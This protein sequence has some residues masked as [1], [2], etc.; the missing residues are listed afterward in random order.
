[1]SDSKYLYYSI[2]FIGLILFSYL[3]INLPINIPLAI[4]LGTSVVVLTFISPDV[5]L[6]VL[7][8]SMLLSPEIKVAGVPGRAVTIR[9]DDFLVFLV[10]FTWLVRMGINKEIGLIKHTPLNAPMLYYIGACIISSGWGAVRN[11]VNWKSSMFF[12]LKFVEYFMIYFLVSN[13]IRDEKQIKRFLIAGMITFIIVTI[14]GYTQVGFGR[15]SAPF[16]ENEPATYG[17]YI[18]FVLA[19]IFGL[20]IYAETLTQ[21]IVFAGLFLF[22][23]QPF[24]YTYS[25]ASYI[26]FFVMSI[27][28]SLFSG[29]KRIFLFV[30][31]ACFLVF[32]PILLPDSVK[33]RI[34]ET[35]YGNTMQ[36]QF[37]SLHLDESSMARLNSWK[38]V[39]FEKWTKHF[40]FGFGITGLGFVDSQYVRVLGELG[41]VGAIIF[42][43]LMVSIMKNAWQVYMMEHPS[44]IK[45]LTIGFIGGYIGLLAH[46]L[47]SNTF[48]IVRVM[49]PFWFMTAV[50]IALP[51]IIQQGDSHV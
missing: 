5:G 43:W 12:I 47:G 45:G 1:M 34:Q 26:G 29:K 51:R 49:E 9:F 14:Y 24:L 32:L 23:L 35:F 22:A 27:F 10:F 46:A 15:V 20:F 39:I 48:I 37:G 6:I 18:V 31:L 25:R 41:V 33:Q 16:D 40:L 21:Q 2:F 44:W 42:L 50:I 30:A 3:M 19:I 36:T 7:I 17:A 38:A 8:F 4:L 28:L 13:I 11:D